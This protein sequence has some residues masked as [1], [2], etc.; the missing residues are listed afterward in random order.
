MTSSVRAQIIHDAIAEEK[1]DS[2]LFVSDWEAN[3]DDFV[4][5]APVVVA[6]DKLL[7]ADGMVSSS[8]A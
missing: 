8:L 2:W 5:F 3:Q 6:I 1:L 4:D 7:Q